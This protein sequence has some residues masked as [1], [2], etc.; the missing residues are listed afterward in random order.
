MEI[1]IC[2]VEI[3]S[4]SQPVAVQHLRTYVIENERKS[5]HR[6][7]CE[8]KQIGGK[9]LKPDKPDNVYAK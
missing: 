8:K 7:G 1:H 5:T 3:M 9:I 2:S 6:I 4:S